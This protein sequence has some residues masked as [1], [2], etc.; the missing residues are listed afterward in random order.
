MVEGINNEAF[1]G[2]KRF[3]VAKIEFTFILENNV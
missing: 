2:V 3:K 1:K